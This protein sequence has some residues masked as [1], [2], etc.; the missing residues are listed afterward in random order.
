MSMTLFL[1]PYVI[2]KTFT[3]V[4]LAGFPTDAQV[5]SFKIPNMSVPPCT[6]YKVRKNCI[7]KALLTKYMLVTIVLV[8]LC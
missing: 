2:F 7:P 4:F 5:G 6:A 1:S 8:Y 3:E